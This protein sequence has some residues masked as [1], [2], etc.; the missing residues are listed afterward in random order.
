MTAT[1]AEL[2]GGV[3]TELHIGGKDV[4]SADGARFDVVDPASGEVIA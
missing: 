4:P 2:L 1:I 3:P